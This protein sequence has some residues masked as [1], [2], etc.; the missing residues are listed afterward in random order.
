MPLSR[1]KPA[2]QPF[3]VAERNALRQRLLGLGMKPQDVAFLLNHTGTRGQ[4]V[5]ILKEKLRGYGAN[6]LRGKV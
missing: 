1:P 2:N 3:E 4:A 5:G 6:G